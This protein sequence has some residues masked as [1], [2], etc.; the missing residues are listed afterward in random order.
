M[1]NKKITNLFFAAI[2]FCGFNF[3]VSA[4]PIE[5]LFTAATD[6]LTQAEVNAKLSEYDVSELEAN[7]FIA[8]ID[9]GITVIGDDA[10][11]GSL[12][13]FNPLN[14]NLV[15]VIAPTVTTIGG[16]QVFNFCSNLK[17]VYFPNVTTIGI[18]AF[19]GTGLETVSFPLVTTIGPGAFAGC[20]NLV[21]VDFPL[22]T[23]IEQGAFSGCSNLTSVDFPLVTTIKIRAFYYC[24]SLETVNFPLTTRIEGESFGSCISLTSI[25]FGTGFETETEIEFHWNVFKDVPT[26]NVELTLGN[27][28][29][30]PDLDAM[31]WH[32]DKGNGTGIPYVWKMI[33][34]SSIEETIKNHTVNIFPNPT[35]A[36]FTVSFELEKSCNMKI[37]LSDI[38]GSELLQIYDGFATVGNFS[39]TVKIE[40]LASG[41]YFLK[42]LIDGKYT[43]AKVVVD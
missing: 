36:A 21:N 11:N 42:I 16:I 43:V 1:N 9:G 34:H 24:L 29:P 8:V 19:R 26:E 31:T 5:I 4:Q 39:E 28:L 22:A 37:I 12:Y 38:L 18:F 3:A 41:I 30:L 2:L 15:E 33:K 27:V 14:Q 32:C 25:N 6:T 10:F 40:N 17:Q 7:G 23:T 35:R 20:T 13:P